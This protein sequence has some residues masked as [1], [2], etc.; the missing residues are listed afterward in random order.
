[1]GEMDFLSWVKLFS[2]EFWRGDGTSAGGPEGLRLLVPC[3]LAV[4]GLAAWG[5]LPP[6]ETAG[7]KYELSV[8]GNMV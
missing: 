8:E 7:A 2:R 5:Q 3:L 4:S 1:M 6:E